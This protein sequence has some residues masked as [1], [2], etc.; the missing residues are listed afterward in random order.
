MK[1]NET[2][3]MDLVGVTLKVVGAMACTFTVLATCGLSLPT[4]ISLGMVVGGLTF[5]VSE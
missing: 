5:V 3:L 4:C 2:S 1:T